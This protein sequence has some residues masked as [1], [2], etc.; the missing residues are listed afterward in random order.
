MGVEVG[1][2]LVNSLGK[3]GAPPGHVLQE[4]VINR[5]AVTQGALVARQEGLNR[6]GGD[7]LAR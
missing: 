6:T 7:P 2:A 1:I 5:L 4:L 3:L